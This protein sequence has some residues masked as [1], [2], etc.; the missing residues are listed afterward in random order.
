VSN[1]LY[2]NEQ[3]DGRYLKIHLKG[4]VSNADAVGARVSVSSA[5][6]LVGVQEVRTLTGF[7]SQAPLELHF[8]LPAV[9]DYQV[10][11][12]FPGGLTASGTYGSGQSVMIVEGN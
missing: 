8:G 11:V 3:N 5:G 1:R 2:R 9:G 7:C 4:T 6:K 12:E 10:D